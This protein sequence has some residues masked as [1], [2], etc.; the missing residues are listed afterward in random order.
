MRQPARALAHELVQQ[1]L[2]A[3]WTLGGAL[4]EADLQQLGLAQTGLQLGGAIVVPLHN[5]KR[6]RIGALLLLCEAEPLPSRVRFAEAVAASPEEASCLGLEAGEPC[7]LVQR[8]SHG[9]AGPVSWAR[10]LHR[11]YV[12][13]GSFTA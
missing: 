10:L 9:A 12:L 6:E 3:D 1:A 13:Q 8:L 7:L 2:G 11:R 4:H 5:R